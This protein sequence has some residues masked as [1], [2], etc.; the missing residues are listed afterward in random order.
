MIEAMAGEIA[1]ADLAALLA[2]QAIGCPA[3]RQFVA[4]FGRSIGHLVEN[5]AEIIPVSYTHLTLPTIYSV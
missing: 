1:C 4:G 5:T 2:A 3:F